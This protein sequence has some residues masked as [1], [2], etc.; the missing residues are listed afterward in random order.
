MTRALKILGALALLN[1]LRGL[2]MVAGFILSGGFD[3]TSRALAETVA[4][5]ALKVLSK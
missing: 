1:E 4:Q 2:L 5:T 3:A